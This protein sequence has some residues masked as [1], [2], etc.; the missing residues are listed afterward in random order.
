M[1][2]AT[3]NEAGTTLRFSLNMIGDENDETHFSHKFY[4]PTSLLSKTFAN[5][6]SANI[7]LSKT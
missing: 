1:K 7:R 6:S 5:N 4:E 3:K 2:S